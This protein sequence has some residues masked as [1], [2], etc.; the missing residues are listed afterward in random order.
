MT[1]SPLGAAC[2][3]LHRAEVLVDEHGHVQQPVRRRQVLQP[4]PTLL[5]WTRRVLLSFAHLTCAAIHGDSLYDKERARRNGATALPPSIFARHRVLLDAD[6][7][8]LD[9]LDILVVPGHHLCAR[10]AML[11]R[12]TRYSAW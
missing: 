2:H 8:D 12:L 1:L 6:A 3:R 10:A 5:A 7:I 9:P 4:A 11:S